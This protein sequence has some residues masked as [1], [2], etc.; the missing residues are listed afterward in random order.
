MRG[1]Y[2]K[3]KRK[4]FSTRRSFY[5]RRRSRGSP[6]HFFHK[7]SDFG[8]VVGRSKP[9]GRASSASAPK[10]RGWSRGRARSA[11]SIYARRQ[12]GRASC[13]ERVE[14]A[15]GAGSVKQR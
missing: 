15:V 12:I 2:L 3:R 7:W 11:R 4:T 13:R 14:I 5:R 9:V 8:Q 10:Q 6:A 1:G